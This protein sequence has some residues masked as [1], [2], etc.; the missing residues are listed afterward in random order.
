[1]TLYLMLTIT[2]LIKSLGQYA[3]IERYNLSKD[4][5]KEGTSVLLNHTLNN[6]YKLSI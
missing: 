2:M 4:V 1:M 5:P 3:A 6:L